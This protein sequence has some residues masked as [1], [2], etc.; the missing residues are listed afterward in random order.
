MP[1][2]K[3]TTQRTTKAA[4]TSPLIPPKPSQDHNVFYYKLDFTRNE[5]I[6]YDKFEG[7][8]RSNTPRVWMVHLNR[9]PEFRFYRIMRCMQLYEVADGKGYSKTVIKVIDKMKSNEFF[10]QY[11]LGT[12]EGTFFATR[13]IQFLLKYLTRQQ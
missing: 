3:A 10:S 2:D 6:L 1:S 9:C 11:A 7:I 8:C 13:D 5:F 4:G 12:L